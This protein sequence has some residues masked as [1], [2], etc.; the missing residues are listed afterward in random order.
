MSM[1][2]M[3]VPSKQASDAHLHDLDERLELVHMQLQVQSV[4]QPHTH[5]LHGGAVPLLWEHRAEGP[6]VSSG[7][8]TKLLI[9]TCT[10]NTTTISA[11]AP[12]HYNTA[13]STERVH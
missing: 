2:S 13:A 1:D 7:E 12:Q 6:G 4:G 8:C 3:E 9:Y 5:G 10:F 11:T